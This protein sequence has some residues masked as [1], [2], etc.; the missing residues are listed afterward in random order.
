[1]KISI[2]LDIEIKNNDDIIDYIKKNYSSFV[3]LVEN[4]G[5]SY[6]PVGDDSDRIEIIREILDNVDEKL[7]LFDVGKS[8]ITSRK[9][10]VN[11]DRDKVKD[12]LLNYF[13][14]ENPLF[15]DFNQM[16]LTE[17]LNFLKETTLSVNGHGVISST[18]IKDIKLSK[19]LCNEIV[20]E[21]YSDGMDYD[22]DGYY[23]APGELEYYEFNLV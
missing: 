7:F 1:M 20:N 13:D 2:S 23:F 9:I 12:Y 3:D 8:K 15:D 22:L 10:I 19:L 6:S 16:S 4:I 5:V 11:L 21:E 18:C 14:E 17:I